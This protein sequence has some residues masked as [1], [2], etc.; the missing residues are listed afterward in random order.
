MSLEESKC[1][2]KLKLFIKPYKGVNFQ[3]ELKSLEEKDLVLIGYDEK[4]RRIIK[5]PPISKLNEK[6]N[7]VVP[8]KFVPTNISSTSDEKRT[9]GNT[10]RLSSETKQ[11]LK[12]MIKGI[13]MSSV[14][15][16]L[17]SKE[18]YEK[19]KASEYPVA[20]CTYLRLA[21]SL[22]EEKVLYIENKKDDGR[23]RIVGLMDNKAK[24]GVDEENA[25]EITIKLNRKDYMV[26]EKLLKEFRITSNPK[27]WLSN[28]VDDNIIYLLDNNSLAFNVLLNEDM[29]KKCQFLKENFNDLGSNLNQVISEM[30]CKF[31]DKEYI[32]RYSTNEF[33]SIMAQ[34]NDKE[35]LESFKALLEKKINDVSAPPP[36]KK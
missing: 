32:N 31:I 12:D 1:R 34:V 3:K 36:M 11:K 24:V 20:Y 21:R 25:D 23:I 18:I 17:T 15:K 4:G 33:N 19:I 7:M 29:W 8:G 10:V 30:V 26:V 2:D 13:I 6:I 14:N 28:L 16:E 22:V 35:C 9:K 5:M 27:E